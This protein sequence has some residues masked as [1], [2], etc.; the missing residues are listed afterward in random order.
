MFLNDYLRS[1]FTFV[2]KVSENRPTLSYHSICP[3]DVKISVED[4]EILLN[5]G[6]DSAKVT[7][8]E[9]PLFILCILCTCFCCLLSFH[10]H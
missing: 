7:T 5:K 4:V 2:D 10:F 6:P 3:E 9:V 8:D 1:M